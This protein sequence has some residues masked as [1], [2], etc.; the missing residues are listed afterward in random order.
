M[1][2]IAMIAADFLAILAFSISYWLGASEGAAMWIGIVIWIIS[3]LLAAVK[4]MD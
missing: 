3:L 4:I 2:F 1:L